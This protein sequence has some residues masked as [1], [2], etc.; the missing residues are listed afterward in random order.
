LGKKWKRLSEGNKRRQ[1]K[2]P[3]FY[4]NCGKN[5]QNQVRIFTFAKIFVPIMTNKQLLSFFF[6]LMSAQYTFAQSGPRLFLDIPHLYFVSPDVENISNVMGLG[7]GTTMNV[8]THWGVVRLGGGATFTVDPK[9]NDLA[10]SFL[11]TPYGLAEAGVGIFRS[12]GNKCAKTNRAAYTVMAKGGTRY[13]FDTRDDGAVDSPFYGIDYT[14]GAEFGYF[15][16]RDVF[17]NYEVSFTADY[18]T[19]AKA[20]GLT[21]GFKLFLNLRADR[22]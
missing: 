22:R 20:V 5:L 4:L 13:R 15:Y 9:S 7:A 16:I 17:K 21:A 3:K 18:Y 8:G 12:N 10:N 19:R 14:V 1:P 6:C 2:V 11:I